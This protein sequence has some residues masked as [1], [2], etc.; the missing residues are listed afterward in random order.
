[1]FVAFVKTKTYIAVVLT[2]VF[3]AKFFAVDAHGLNIVFNGN[4][5]TFV[6]PFCVKLKTSNESH[7]PSTFSQQANADIEMITL[8][9]SCMSPF[10]FELFSWDMHYSNPIAVFDEHF[11]S[12][13]SYRYLDSVSPPPRLV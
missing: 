1:M 3:L 6:N 11:T 5:M 2:F 8:N 9:G 4:D 10:Q 13:L 12:R 7:D